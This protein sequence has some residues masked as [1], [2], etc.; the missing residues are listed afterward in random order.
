MAQAW[1]PGNRALQAKERTDLA[2]QHLGSTGGRRFS[3]NDG[4][5]DYTASFKAHSGF[6]RTLEF[7]SLE[8]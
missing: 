2:N 5:H 7:E 6:R 8:F 3:Y 4:F 1:L